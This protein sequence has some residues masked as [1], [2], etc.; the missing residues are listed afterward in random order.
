MWNVE[1][2]EIPAGRGLLDGGFSGNVIVVPVDEI[3]LIYQR[4]AEFEA[5]ISRH[6]INA[7]HAGVQ[8]EMCPS[9]CNT[10]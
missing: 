1:N 3:L 8:W 4:V 2:V 9:M 6:N 10:L 5:S 7:D